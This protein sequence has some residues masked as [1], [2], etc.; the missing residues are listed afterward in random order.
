[1]LRSL[2]G[3]EMCIRD[4]F[5]SVFDTEAFNTMFTVEREAR[6]ALQFTGLALQ[7]YNELS[8]AASRVLEGWW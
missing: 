8:I 6:E 4:R 3:S 5:G 2:V 1:M 7:G